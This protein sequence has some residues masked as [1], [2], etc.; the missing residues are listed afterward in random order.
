MDLPATLLLL[1]GGSSSRMRGAAKDKVLLDLNGKPVFRHSLDALNQLPFF[2]SVVLVT[3]D[4]SQRRA[5]EA[6]LQASNPPFTLQWAGGGPTRQESVW[7]GLGVA[8][9]EP[10]LVFIHDAARPLVVPE[11][12]EQLYHLAVEDGSAVLAHSVTDTIKRVERPLETG[13]RQ[14]LYTLDRDRLWAVETPQVFP[15]RDIRKAYASARDAAVSMTDDCS[16]LERLG[17]PISL[18]ENPHP[19]PKITRPADVALVRFLLQ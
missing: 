7:N 4:E 5:I 3:R 14:P 2:D 11:I 6:G 8:P 19:N 10:R 16:A 18:L 1:C 13:R 9:P 15:L 12:W 17:H